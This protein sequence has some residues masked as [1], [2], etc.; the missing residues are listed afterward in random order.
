M[1]PG[2]WKETF[3]MVVR[4]V[5]SYGVPVLVS[6]NVGAKDILEKQ[7]GMGIVVAVGEEN[8]KK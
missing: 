4:E 6:Q 1:L 7:Q 5:L 3:G 2:V 8:L